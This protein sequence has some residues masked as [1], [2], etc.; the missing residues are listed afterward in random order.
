MSASDNFYLMF[1]LGYVNTVGKFMNDEMK[2]I[3]KDYLAPSEWNKLNDD[4]LEPTLHEK[5]MQYYAPVPSSTPCLVSNPA[6]YAAFIRIYNHELDL[7][8]DFEW[9]EADVV[10]WLDNIWPQIYNENKKVA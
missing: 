3:L 8:I 9:S 1:S 10:Y 4:N 6:L 5:I 7:N 2:A